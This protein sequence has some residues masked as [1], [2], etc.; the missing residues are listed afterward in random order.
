MTQ[1][2]SEI[3]REKGFFFPVR[4]ED[5]FDNK[6]NLAYIKA[7]V[8][9]DTDAHL[10]YVS[11]KYAPMTNEDAF[12]FLDEIDLKLLK[13]GLRKGGSRSFVIG[14]LSEV[15]VLGDCHKLHVVVENSFDGST[16][17]R[18]SFC[19]LRIVC[20]N[21]LAQVFRGGQGNVRLFHTPSIYAKA[22]TAHELMAGASRYV[23]EYVDAAEKLASKKLADYEMIDLIRNYFAQAKVAK[24]EKAIQKQQEEAEKV[25]SLLR[26]DD[27]ANFQGTAWQVINAM[28]NYYSHLEPSKKTKEEASQR[29]YF[30]NMDRDFSEFATAL[31]AA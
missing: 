29:R 1:T 2:T 17:Y 31:L 7:V 16:P 11:A 26:A 10:G 18:A 22:E 3:L 19:M 12:S 27:H 28:T 5:L 15:T 8:N 4:K 20:E 21:Q 23:A 24:T 30:Q 9:A 25:I 14:E 6:G 13:Y